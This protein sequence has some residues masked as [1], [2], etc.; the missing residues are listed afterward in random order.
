[1]CQIL[2]AAAQFKEKTEYIGPFNIL[3]LDEESGNQALRF[4]HS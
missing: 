4:S 3:Q 1:M 2:Q